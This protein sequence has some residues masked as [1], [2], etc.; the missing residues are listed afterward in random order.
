M[1]K[2]TYLVA[3]L[4]LAGTTPLLTGCVDTD[5]PSG[6][7]E[8]RGAKAELLKAKAAV[9]AAKVATVQ[10]EAAYKNAEAEY[11]KAEAALVLAKAAYWEAKTE[12]EKA[13]AQQALN[14]AIEEANR[15]AAWWEVE[16]KKLQQEYLKVIAETL[17][18]NE[19]YLSD[20]RGA[21]SVAKIDLDKAADALV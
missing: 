3:S 8:L 20:Y 4:L 13:A 7:E 16:F 19:A 6:I 1:K 2:W 15:A 12:N 17:K 5:E 18:A 21:L 9:E 11:K 10:A 14:A